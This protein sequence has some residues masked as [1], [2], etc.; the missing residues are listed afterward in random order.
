MGITVTQPNNICLEMLSNDR[1]IQGGKMVFP[2][3]CYVTR[4]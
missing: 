1:V 4:F 2:Q 3:L